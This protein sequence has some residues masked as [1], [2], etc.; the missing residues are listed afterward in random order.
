MAYYGRIVLAVPPPDMG[1][2][3]VEVPAEPIGLEEFAEES[4][5]DVESG[6]VEIDAQPVSA[7]HRLNAFDALADED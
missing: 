5:S 7:Q 3:P 1:A 6:D 4:E 2:L